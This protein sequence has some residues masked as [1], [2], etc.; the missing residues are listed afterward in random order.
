M[1]KSI[2]YQYMCA[3]TLTNVDRNS[4]CPC[5]IQAGTCTGHQ[6]PHMLLICCATWPCGSWESAGLLFLD[7]RLWS[8]SFKSLYVCVCTP[9]PR[10]IKHKMFCSP[11]NLPQIDFISPFKKRVSESTTFEFELF[12]NTTWKE[13]CHRLWRGPGLGH[14]SQTY[15]MGSERL[16][17]MGGCSGKEG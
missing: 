3:L 17:E 9:Q 8:V 11:A 7:V 1:Q 16:T 2:S 5:G 10:F 4:I 15:S 6:R 14:G 13:S 12:H